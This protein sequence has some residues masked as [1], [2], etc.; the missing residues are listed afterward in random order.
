MINNLI[1]NIGRCAMLRQ[2]INKMNG[3]NKLMMF[4]SYNNS[5]NKMSFS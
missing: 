1:K 3:D 2:K 5:T 4:M